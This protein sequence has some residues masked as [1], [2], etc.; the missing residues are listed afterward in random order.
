MACYDRT[1]TGAPIV[2]VFATLAAGVLFAEAYRPEPVPAGS[3]VLLAVVALGLALRSGRGVAVAA[4]VVLAFVGVWSSAADSPPPRI[5]KACADSRYRA[6]VMSPT[7]RASNP[8]THKVVQRVVLQLEEQRCADRWHSVSGRVRAGLWSGPIVSRGDLIE[9]RL[10]ILP[11]RLQRNPS[12]P[13]PVRLARRTG[14]ASGARVQSAH[15]IAAFGSGLGALIDRAR[16][17]TAERLERVLPP[18]QAAIAKALALGDRGGI[19]PEVR[20]RW[21]RAGVAHLLAISGLHVGLIAGLVW[22]LLRFLLALLPG[23]GERCSTRRLAAVTTIPVVVL[24]CL[25]VGAPA[26]AVRATVMVVAFLAGLAIGRPSNGANALGIAGSLLLLADPTSVYDAG[27][28]LSFAAAAALLLMPR[29]PHVQGVGR[30]LRRLIIG[31]ALASIAATLATAPI[32]AY[33]FGQVSLIAP[34]T[35]LVAVPLGAM[36]ATPAALAFSVLA[37]PTG[38]LESSLGAVLHFLL[39]LLDR[40][41]Q[42][43]AAIPWAAVETP[44]PSGLEIAAYLALLG[45]GIAAYFRKRAVIVAGFAL[46][47]IGAS[48][49]VRLSERSGD[50]SL[51]VTHPYVGQGESTVIT[52]PQGGVMVVDA[53]GWL[54]PGGWDPG[55]GVLAPLLR[56]R[57]VRTIDLAVLTHP[58]P[59]HI[60][61]F[62]Y[63]AEHF[64]IRELWWSGVGADDPLQRRVLDRVRA[65]GG[66][67]RV[68]AELPAVTELEGATIELLHP[69][70]AGDPDNMPYFPELS[71]NDNS[72]VLR[73][74]FGQRSVLL[75]ADIE[76][77]AE[78][79]LGRDLRRTDI[80]KV[81]HHGSST[82]STRALIDAVAPLV[83]VISCGDANSFGFPDAAVVRRYEDGGATVLRTDRDG[84][85]EMRTDGR[86]W[87]VET[88]LGRS[89]SP[90]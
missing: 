90:P 67:V 70:P 64:S 3:L 33:H 83:V 55:R 20:D 30:R 13:D 8:A 21:A 16:F 17:A 85:I 37:W 74:S 34:L 10:D 43:A 82:S 78:T 46:L 45:A 44:K 7:E 23:A 49:V 60:G 56:M 57:G 89:L 72:I 73:L 76:A 28:L 36:L 62:A 79:R 65:E 87:R 61:G 66:Q 31:T 88:A 19:E 58:H 52:L 24:F 50:G 48:V 75:P 39:G 71:V 38:W 4:L 25:W 42:L 22:G 68:A 69:R 29:L 26:S 40:F 5:R 54:R 35:N 11:R 6:R 2:A 27:F 86:S 51:R 47:L 41:V 80:L 1:V 81:P 59:D 63:L 14:V 18:E 9:L 84:M 77:V 12:D 32:T 15:V 53:G